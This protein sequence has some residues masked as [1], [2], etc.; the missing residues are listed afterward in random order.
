MGGKRHAPAALA[1]GKTRYPLSKR[2]GEPHGQAGQVR[3]ISPPPGFDP[4]TVQPVAIRYI[5]NAV[6]APYIRH[7]PTKSL[8]F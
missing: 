6:P 2:L 3:K 4:W 1:P 8:K 7:I 5:D